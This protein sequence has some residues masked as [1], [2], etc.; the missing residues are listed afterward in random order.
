YHAKA[1]EITG[2]TLDNS[3]LP[4][5]AS[6]VFETNPQTVT[7]VY[8][9]VPAKIKAHDST[10]YVGDTWSAEDNFDSAVNSVGAAVSFDDVKVEGKVDT[11]KA[12]VYPVTYS[13]SGEAVTINVTVKA[14]VIPAPPVTP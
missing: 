9:A 10:I 5:N 4:A 14:K 12:G 13:F 6:G 3:K 2:F 8:N 1:K 11:T 7:Y